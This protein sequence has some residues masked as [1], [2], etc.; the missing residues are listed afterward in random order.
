[1]TMMSGK[2]F[3]LYISTLKKRLEL[4]IFIVYVCWEAMEQRSSFSGSTI[5]HTGRNSWPG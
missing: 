3:S 4:F 2:C 1:M 5:H